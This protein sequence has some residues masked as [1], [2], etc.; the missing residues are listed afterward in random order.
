MEVDRVLRP[1]GY[2]ILSGPPINWKVNYK[3]WQRPKEDLQEEQRK[4]EEAAKLLCWEKK[5]EHGE[6]AI[7][8][9]RVNDE[10][11]RSR[12]DDPRANFCKTDDTDDVW[13][14][15][16]EACITPYPET[17]SSDE[18]AGGELQ[19]FP[20]RLN[21]VPPRISSGSI[22][23]VTV[24]AYEDDNRQWKKHVKAYKRIN[25]L[26]DTGRYRNIM[27]MNAGFGGFAA[28][29]ESQKLWVMNVVPTIAEKNRL[30]VVY[31]RGLIGIYH[32]WCEAFSTYPRT[33]DLIHANH[34]FSLYK[35]KC[36]ADDILLEMDR[37]LRPEGAVII[38]DDVDTLIK[39]KRIIA[40]MRWDAKLVDHEDGP[41]VPEKVLIAVKQYWVTNS[42]STH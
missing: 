15:K 37:I 7:W 29:L 13:Y 33:Y 34:L 31:E 2:W 42:T 19:A 5:Y 11:C 27:D 14:K 38:R 12:Q 35:N 32:D 10:A 18:V 3:A 4:I 26:L 40:G 16:M 1:G 20:D 36:N 24:D 39:V 22:S 28:A 8:Q 30:G 21:A 25:S 41:L 17:S 6:I 9:K 23:G